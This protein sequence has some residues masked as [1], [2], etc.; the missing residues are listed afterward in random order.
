MGYVPP[1]PPPRTIYPQIVRALR[2]APILVDRDYD[3]I[4]THIVYQGPAKEVPAKRPPAPP[5]PKPLE[6]TSDGSE[7]GPL[8]ALATFLIGLFPPIAIDPLE[9]EIGGV[10]WPNL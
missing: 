3:A 1:S 6:W 5:P 8:G 9:T 7:Y 2:P 4:A 10:T